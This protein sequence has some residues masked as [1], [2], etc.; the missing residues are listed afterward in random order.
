MFA[1]SDTLAHYVLMMYEVA[2]R[3]LF[4]AELEEAVEARTKDSN[5]VK[6]ALGLKNI[7]FQDV[8]YKLLGCMKN[9]ANFRKH[10]EKLKKQGL[11]G[12]DDYSLT[13]M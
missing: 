12:Y 2:H 6:T 3:E 8:L 5:F 13:M 11:L 7:H 10:I 4:A 1:A 9:K